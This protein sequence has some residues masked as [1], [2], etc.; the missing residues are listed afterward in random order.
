VKRYDESVK[1]YSKAHEI[2]QTYAP[3]NEALVGNMSKVLESAL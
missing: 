2:A 1:I 3:S